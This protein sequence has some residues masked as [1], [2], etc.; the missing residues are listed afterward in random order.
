MNAPASPAPIP[1]PGRRRWLRAAV[2]QPLVLPLA[3]VAVIL[4]V[5]QAISP[6]FAAPRQV[7]DQLTIA[8]FLAIVAAGQNL[9]IL[10]GRE[11]IDLSVGGVL[12]LGALVAGNVMAGRDAFI[13][14]ALLATLAVGFAVGTFNGLGASVVRIPPLVM[15]LGTN[16]VIQGLLVF[17][18]RGQPSGAAAP[19]L[20]RLVVKPLWLEVPGV[21]FLW[22]GVILL[23]AF[24]LRYTRFGLSL[25]AVGANDVAAGFAGVRVGVVRILAYGCSGL[26]AAGGG[27]LLL[28]YTGTMFI[29]VGEQYALP[30]V[31]A[32]VIGG[33]ALSGGSGRYAGTVAG[34]IMLTFL[35]GLLITLRV[36]PQV[37]QII[38]GTTLLLFMLIYGREKSLRA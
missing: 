7:Y 31:I 20:V 9:V 24:A 34:A 21:L 6:G 26:L 14:P 36:E 35:Q 19:R 33:T 30:S 11:G 12:T 8:A 22:A 28:G 5:G 10:S 1:P 4:A 18:T 29:G 25:Y 27:F 38:F 13:L 2:R 3:A 16:G 37:R 32:V 23:V 17:L 15:T